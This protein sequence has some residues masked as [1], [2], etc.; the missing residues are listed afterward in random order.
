M[1]CALT[2]SVSRRDDQARPFRNPEDKAMAPR[3]SR[4]LRQQCYLDG[5]WIDA[6]DNS[7][8]EAINNP[9]VGHRL[10]TVPTLG[11]AETCRAIAAAAKAFPEWRA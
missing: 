6:D 1:P 4:L 7:A 9:A 11:T 2:V 8:V 3:D 5:N 10:G